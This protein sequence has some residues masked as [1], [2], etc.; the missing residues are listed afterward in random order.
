MLN[1]LHFLSQNTHSAATLVF[2]RRRVDFQSAEKG[3]RVD[4]GL[5]LTAITFLFPS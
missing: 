4:S 3:P 2:A 5:V 1:V